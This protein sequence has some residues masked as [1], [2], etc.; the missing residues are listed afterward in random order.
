MSFEFGTN[1]EYYSCTSINQYRNT[2]CSLDENISGFKNSE[3][4]RNR[5]KML[6]ISNRYIIFEYLNEQRIIKY[7]FDYENRQ[8]FDFNIPQPINEIIAKF[9]KKSRNKEKYKAFSILLFV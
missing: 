9:L 2:K 3:N 5:T 8:D 4:E 7:N 6:D 1:L